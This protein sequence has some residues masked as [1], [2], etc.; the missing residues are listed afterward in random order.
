MVEEAWALY[1][2]L[3]RLYVQA[4]WFSWEE[5]RLIRLMDRARNR[6]RRRLSLSPLVRKVQL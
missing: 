1:M 2:R 3:E 4:A 6:W 5:R